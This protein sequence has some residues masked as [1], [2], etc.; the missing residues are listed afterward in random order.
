MNADSLYCRRFL[1]VSRPHSVMLL[2]T[3]KWIRLAK[4]RTP[5]RFIL[6]QSLRRGRKNTMM[7]KAGRSSITK[8]LSYLESFGDV[9]FCFVW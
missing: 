1:Y 7:A 8:G 5:Y 9:V 4:G 2:G 3:N 6:Y